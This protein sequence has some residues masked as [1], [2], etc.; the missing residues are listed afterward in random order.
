[1]PWTVCPNPAGQDFP[2]HLALS[3]VHQA[4]IV[5]LK[6]PFWLGGS[7]GGV[8]RGGCRVELICGDEGEGVQEERRS[9]AL[10]GGEGFAPLRFLAS[11]LTFRLLTHG[12]DLF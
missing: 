2:Q 9:E 7:W 12:P 10:T 6:I 8:G 1:M 5:I 3:A 11:S 4:P